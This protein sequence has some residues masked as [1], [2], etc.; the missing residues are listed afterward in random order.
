MSDHINSLRFQVE[1][2]VNT[3]LIWACWLLGGALVAIEFLGW[4]S[5][6]TTGLGILFI[7]LGH[8]RHQAGMIAALAAREIEAYELG[9]KAVRAVPDR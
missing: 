8:D 4:G 2:G 3:L 9:R 7:A 6:E 5:R 1:L